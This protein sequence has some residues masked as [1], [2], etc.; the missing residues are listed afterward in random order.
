[1]E[2]TEIATTQ[3]R[4]AHLLLR[5]YG[6]S[7]AY[8]D[9]RA[10]MARQ[11]D[12]GETS[13][14]AQSE[15]RI[16][17]TFLNHRRMKRWEKTFRFPEDVLANIGQQAALG[18]E[19]NEFTWLVLTESWCGDAAP[20]LPIAEA[21]A[22]AVPGLE[23]RIADRDEHP[24]LM[25]LVRTEGALSIPKLLVMSA[26]KRE[27]LADWGPRPAPA[28]A[29]V[30]A[31]KTKHGKLTAAFREELQQWYNKDKGR[32]IA[33]ELAALLTLEDVGNSAFL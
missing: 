6:D 12:A 33:R 28:A 23:L 7:L 8:P 15:D 18:K 31:Y 29:L 20:M 14:D 24:E 26:D 3:T 19:R 2:K 9:Y 13:G 25:D 30:R 1:M 11:A 4:L 21:F 16:G 5:A 22:Q 27:I 17:Y 10:E 32:S